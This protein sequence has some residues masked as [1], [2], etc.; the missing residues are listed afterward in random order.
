MSS[1]PLSQVADLD[2]TEL[3]VNTDFEVLH[4]S[5]GIIAQVSIGLNVIQCCFNFGQFLLNGQQR[6][7][8]FSGSQLSINGFNSI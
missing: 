3:S 5:H 6:D 7:F 8:S 1:C 2:N 4:G